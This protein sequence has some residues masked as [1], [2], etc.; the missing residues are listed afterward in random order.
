MSYRELT[1][2]SDVAHITCKSL[3]MS[4]D[5]SEVKNLSAFEKKYI[6]TRVQEQLLNF[7][8]D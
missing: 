6:Y 7:L 5:L 1:T 3:N 2:E 8:L 4:I